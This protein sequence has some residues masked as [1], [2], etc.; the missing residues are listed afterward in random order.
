MMNIGKLALYGGGKMGF[1]MLEGWLDAGLKPQDVAVFDPY[2]SDILTASGVQVNPEHFTADIAI[3]AVKPQIMPDL[4]EDLQLPK[5]CLVISV[6]AGIP[7]AKFEAAL[8]EGQRII[9]SMPNTPAA[10]QAGITA[11]IGNKAST[12]QDLEAAETLLQ[13]V[14]QVVRLNDEREMDAVTGVS[15]SGPAYVFYMIEAMRA[16]GEAQGLSPELSHALALA[17]VA[18][19]GKLA[20][21]SGIDPSTLRQNVTSPGGTTQAGLEVL[22]NEEIGL[23]PL[24][25][26]TV[27]AAS[28]RSRELGQK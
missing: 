2:P 23:K 18:G 26:A 27:A 14:G 1:A 4:L 12:E 13:A 11:I 6:A 9:R 17:T 7:L 19:A 16:A 25:K 8:G 15:G 22:M 21:E 20:A 24:M 28:E 5:E 10:V 3:L